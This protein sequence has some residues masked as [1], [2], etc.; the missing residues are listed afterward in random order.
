LDAAYTQ[1]AYAPNA[2]QI[3]KGFTSASEW[4]LAHI[5]ML[6]APVI[7]AYGSLETPEFQRQARDFA[8]AIMSAG[9][10]VANPLC[11]N[12]GQSRDHSQLFSRDF[13]KPLAQIVGIHD[14]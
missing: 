1:L 9:K 5:G 10:K 14:R 2:P 8:S 13:C 7:V 4:S 6:R 11:C 3:I 12:A